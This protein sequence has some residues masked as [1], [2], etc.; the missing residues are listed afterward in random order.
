MLERYYHLVVG[1]IIRNENFLPQL[2]DG[3]IRRSYTLQAGFKFVLTFNYSNRH[4]REILRLMLH[5]IIQYWNTDSLLNDH[6]GINPLTTTAV[7]H[8]RRI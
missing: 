1:V 8:M 5:L 2:C 3:D 6:I 7:G 4:S